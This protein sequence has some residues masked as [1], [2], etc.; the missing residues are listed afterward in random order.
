M[1]TSPIHWTLT[2]IWGLNCRR[3]CPGCDSDLS[4]KE[5]ITHEVPMLDLCQIS[6]MQSKVNKKVQPIDRSLTW[7]IASPSWV[8]ET[9]TQAMH[10]NKIV[11]VWGWDEDMFGAIVRV[12]VDNHCHQSKVL[13]L[14]DLDSEVMSFLHDSNEKLGQLLSWPERMC[15]YLSKE[16]GFL[17]L[18]SKH[19]LEKQRQLFSRTDLENNCRC[20][21]SVCYLRKWCSNGNLD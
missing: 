1:R 20:F 8:L 3:R 6:K 2:M 4:C 15:W 16:T 14:S 17:F 7:M 9:I 5:E 11:W 13:A 21:S 10:K 12:C 19:T 18:V